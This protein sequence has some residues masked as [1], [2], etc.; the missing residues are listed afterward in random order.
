MTWAILGPV[1]D[2]SACCGRAEVE[3]VTAVLVTAS[4]THSGPLIRNVYQDKT[5]AWENSALDKIAQAIDQAV[6]QLTDVR[7]GIGH[8]VCYIGYNRLPVQANGKV[9]WLASN[10][11][12]IPTS[13]V[14]P[15]VTV[16][17]VDRQDGTPLAI[18]V[19]YACHAVVF[20][21]DNLQYS[22]DWPGAMRRTVEETMEGH[23]L[24]FFLQGAAGNINPYHATTAL[25][26]DA[27]GM[28]NLTG[29]RLGEV[30]SRVAEA[31]V[32][33]QE[34]EGQLDYAADQLRVPLRWEPENSAKG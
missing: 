10:P 1:I 19:N 26:E 5:P 34:A 22:A 32:P 3:W 4:H 7:I 15:T 11:T 17:R 28:S 24:C 12:E 9:K 31:I 13:P 2:E 18:L 25:R 21:A 29:R 8:G 16:L 6:S 23:P 33:G 30:A 27:I 20:A 14:D